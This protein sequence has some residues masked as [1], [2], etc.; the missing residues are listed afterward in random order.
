VRVLIAHSRYLSGDASGENRVVADEARLLSEAGHDV[1]VWTPEP[2]VG[3]GDVLRTAASAI[4]S[5]RATRVVASAI[6]RHRPDV[7]HV[8]NLFPMLSPAVV[9]SAHRRGVPVVATLHNYRL[10]CLPANFLRDGRVCEACMGRVPWRGVAYR[11]FRGSVSGSAVLASSLTLHRA[12]GSFD[13]VRRF[14]AVSGFVKR[15]H[16]EAGIAPERIVVKPNFAWPVAPREGPGEYFLFLGRVAPEKGVDTLLRAWERRRPRHDLVVMGYG[17]EAL[18]DPPAGVE[19]RPPVPG[20]DVADV[21]RRA[22]A[23]LVPSRWYEAAPRTIVEAFAA[24]VPVVASDL[25]ALPEL[26]GPETGALAPPDDV[27]AWSQA[28]GR[29]DDDVES[30]RLGEGALRAW[31]ERYS[32]ERGVEALV[33]AYREAS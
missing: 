14:L 2:E 5:T 4:W 19:L 3:G 8:H 30:A 24:G 32:P 25:G 11:C 18:G 23:V 16:V 26:V 27:G 29:L 15:K 17:V 21:V 28:V 12:S 13:R 31:R 6:E 10:M 1:A 22:R 7:L 9:R 33:A 20:A